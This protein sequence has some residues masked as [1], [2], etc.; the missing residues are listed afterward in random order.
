MNAL[1]IIGIA[2]A[3]SF[4]GGL[5]YL[6]HKSRQL[7][8]LLFGTN[9]LIEGLRRR[10]E[11]YEESPKSVAGMTRVELPRI[12]ADF[13][14]FHWPEWRQ[15]CELLLKRYLKA[16][17]QQNR[18]GLPDGSEAIREQLQLRI[19][20]AVR[21]GIRERF[22][23]IYVHQTEIARYERQSA[24]C[25]IIV[26][27]ALEYR[28]PVW[29]SGEQAQ[30]S[31]EVRK[32]QHRFQLELIHVQ[33]SSRVEGAATGLHCPNCGAP[34]TDLGARHCQYCGI[35]LE[36]MNIRIWRLDRLEER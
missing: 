25:R 2:A 28:H 35:E 16:V 36:A 24:L 22:E 12:R 23:E 29:Q 6:R 3:V 34:V 5:F 18:A 4:L 10:E 17:E 11:L 9:S 14:E 21:R 15:R 20:D 27:T 30:R 26:Q 33:D 32:G 8:R 31:G 1:T 7:S 13:P 19:E